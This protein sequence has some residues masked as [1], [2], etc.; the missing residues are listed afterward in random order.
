MINLKISK[1]AAK[2]KTIPT[3]SI[4][5]VLSDMYINYKHYFQQRS[6]KPLHIVFLVSTIR[7][8]QQNMFLIQDGRH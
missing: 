1:M 6:T 7:S 5:T 2:F 8:S 3:N 4:N